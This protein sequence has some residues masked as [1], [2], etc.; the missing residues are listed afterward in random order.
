[1]LGVLQEPHRLVNPNDAQN[2]QDNVLAGTWTGLLYLN[3]TFAFSKELDNKISTL[4][5]ADL[6]AAIKK[7]LDPAKITI[8][9]AGDF[10]KA[11]K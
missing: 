7:Y 10:A 8:V 3:R 2:A 4:T 5:A 11:A 9:K 1:M 6:Q